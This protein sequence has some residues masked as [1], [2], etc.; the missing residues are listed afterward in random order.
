M[1]QRLFL[2]VS[3]RF[4]CCHSFMATMQVMKERWLTEREGARARV[5]EGERGTKRERESQREKE[6]AG[7]K[8]Q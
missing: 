5:A 8:E 6:R 1:F 3:L 4:V 7:Q 2:F